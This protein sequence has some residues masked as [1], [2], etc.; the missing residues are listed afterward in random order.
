MKRTSALILGVVFVLSILAGATS[1]LAVQTSVV[2]VLTVDDNGQSLTVD[3]ITAFNSDGTVAGKKT[4]VSSTSFVLEAGIYKIVAKKS[5]YKDADRDLTITAQ[6][7]S[8]LATS[9]LTLQ[10]S[11]EPTGGTGSGT[12]TGT[13]SQD[14]TVDLEISEDKT[15]PG[16]VVTFDLDIEN[17]AEYDAEEVE[18]TLTIKGI[19]EDGDDVEVEAEVFD[20]NDE[21]SDD[22]TETLSLTMRVPFKADEGEYDVTVD[23]EWKNEDTNERFVNQVVE[24]K[25]IEVE[26]QDHDVRVTEI[27]L[28]ETAVDAGKDVQVGITIFNVGLEDENVKIHVK[29]TELNIDVTSGQFELDE[30][31]ETTQYLSFAVPKNA[32]NGEYVVQATVMFGD[33]ESK[34]E[35]ATLKVGGQGKDGISV[36][37][38]VTTIGDDLGSFGLVLSIII[39]L[40]VIAL[41][42]KEF[43]PASWGART[44]VIRRR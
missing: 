25:A 17:T 19:D 41:V 29:S 27:V 10:K 31:E 40:I 30:G 1:T 24:E 11:N 3:S 12:G 38:L 42:S 39:A 6:S 43:I 35:F 5:G 14:L 23:I 7:P 20:L 15:A 9:I 8:T 34:T 13:T 16:D 18:V 28:S 32:K 37:P 21:G 26:R 44:E 22:N 2:P 33:S 4:V 36:L